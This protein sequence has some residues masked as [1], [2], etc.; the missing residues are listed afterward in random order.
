[1]LDKIKDS[2]RMV[3]DAAQAS[4]YYW[5]EGTL[6]PGQSF[7][8]PVIDAQGK[9]I[10]AYTFDPTGSPA[11]ILFRVFVSYDQSFPSFVYPISVSTTGPSTGYGV[12]PARFFKLYILA[13]STAGTYSYKAA[14]ALHPHL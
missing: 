6:Q 3:V 10:L 7:Y 2:G 4:E 5:Y 12:L 9:T 11:S 13:S 1:M 8:S 14:L